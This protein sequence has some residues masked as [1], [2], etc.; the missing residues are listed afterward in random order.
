MEATAYHRSSGA[1]SHL[2]AL[3]LEMT[4]FAVV[5]L[6]GDMLAQVGPAM[7]NTKLT[8]INATAPED[9]LRE[10]CLPN[11][12]HVAASD[13][14]LADSYTQFLRHRNWL[15][16]LVL[17]GDQP[18]DKEMA[19]AFQ[20][21]ADRNGVQVVA[22]KQ[23]T[24]STDPWG[25]GVGISRTNPAEHPPYMTGQGSIPPVLR[26]FEMARE[27]NPRLKKVGVAWNPDAE[28]ADILEEKTNYA[29]VCFIIPAVE[30]GPG[31]DERR[32]QLVGDRIIQHREAPPLS[33]EKRGH[34]APYGWVGWLDTRNV[35]YGIA[36]LPAPT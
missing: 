31:R 28:H 32:E 9:S 18:R 13:R 2:R 23:F 7:A 27:A 34:W 33:G 30:L 20:Q 4:P 19:D 21:S 17:Q 26:L 15:K 3:R 1:W 14:M 24:L 25:A 8:L 29:D 16:V 10:L 6:P 22:S 11:V 12:M 36:G 5:D 35:K